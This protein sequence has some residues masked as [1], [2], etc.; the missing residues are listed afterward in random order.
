MPET[1]TCKIRLHDIDCCKGLAI[2]L[3]VIGHITTAKGDF[4]QGAEWFLWLKTTIYLFHMP[5]FMFLSGLVSFHSY[6]PVQ[7]WLGYRQYLR[8]RIRRFLPAYILFGLLISVGKTLTAPYAHVDN[9]PPDI[10]SDLLKFL[11]RPMDSS[12]ASLWYIYVLLAYLVLMPPVL[13]LARNRL[14]PLLGMALILHFLP[15]T[16]LFMLRE[17]SEYAFVF[18]V[19]GIVARHYELFARW[20]DRWWWVWLLVFVGAYSAF[21]CVEVSHKISKLV[22]GLISIPA[23]VGLVRRFGRHSQMLT[24]LGLYT[25][26]IYLMNTL[27]I[28]VVKAVVFRFTPWDGAHFIMIA[29]LLALAG[30]YIPV[31]VK[32]FLFRHMPVLDRITT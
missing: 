19:G 32:R 20:V 11:V 31:F 6:V 24:L 23:L 7:S 29:P 14:V 16:G 25:F 2:S 30:I 13:V 17:I 9:V 12:A 10:L 28:G 22:I 8:R 1:D 5:F 21:A 26:A 18:L 4:P 27:A 15:I 3:V